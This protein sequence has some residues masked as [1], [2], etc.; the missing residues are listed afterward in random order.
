MTPEK[1]RIAIAE[2]CGWIACKRD[3]NIANRIHTDA[4]HS[5]VGI[6]AVVQT[7]EHGRDESKEFN[8][9]FI[10]DYISDL[11]AIHQAWKCLTPDQKGRYRSELSIIAVRESAHRD[12]C[13][14]EDI[15]AEFGP[16][17]FLRTIGKW[18]DSE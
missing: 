15:A 9:W 6:S 1:Q 2:A 10:P 4:P 7:L 17:A 18:E 12:E 16:E 8:Y 11:N 3:S 13:W 14:L 5:W